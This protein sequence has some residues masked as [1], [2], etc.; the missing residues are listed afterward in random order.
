MVLYHFKKEKK[1]KKKKK[2]KREEKRRE[3]TINLKIYENFLNI[4]QDLFQT[5]HLNIQCSLM[6]ATLFRKKTQL[7]YHTKIHLLI[8]M[9]PLCLF[10]SGKRENYVTFL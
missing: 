4:L 10:Y 9:P 5:T 6:V 8:A 2:E 3:K 7:K 1:K